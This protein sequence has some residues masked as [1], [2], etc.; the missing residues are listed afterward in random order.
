[1]QM[2]A[3]DRRKLAAGVVLVAT[4]DGAERGCRVA[5]AATD[6]CSVRAGLV[7]GATGDCAEGA[8]VVARTAADAAEITG[9]KV[10]VIRIAA[11]GDRRAAS[12]VVDRVPA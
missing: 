12:R 8:R 2:P 6:E 3:G 10:R 7:C 1:V 11:T 4:A 5:A 9:D